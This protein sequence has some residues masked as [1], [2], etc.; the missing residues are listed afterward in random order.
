MKRVKQSHRLTT[1][2]CSLDDENNTIEKQIAK[3]YR[4]HCAFKQNK[5]NNDEL[6]FDIAN[7]AHQP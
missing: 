3:F 1:L 7:K 6:K 2:I 4:K 5:N